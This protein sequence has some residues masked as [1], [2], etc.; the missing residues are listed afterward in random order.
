MQNVASVQGTAH[1]QLLDTSNSEFS[2]VKIWAIAPGANANMIY[3]AKETIKQAIPSLD[4]APVVGHLLEAVDADGNKSF[5]FGSHDYGITDDLELKPLTVPFGVVIANTAK[6][7]NVRENDADV[8]YLTVE[9]YLWTG[10]Y[11]ELLEATAT[12]DVWFNQSAEVTFADTRSW[13]VDAKYMEIMDI[14]FSALCILG[15]AKPDDPDWQLHSTRPCFPS[16]RI[17]PYQAFSAEGNGASLFAQLMDEMQSHLVHLFEDYASKKGGNAMLDCEKIA[18]IFAEKNLQQSDVDFA[19]REDMTEEEL[20]AAIDEFLDRV[21]SAPSVDEQDDGEPA[22][23]PVAESDDDAEDAG[24][25]ADEPDD[26]EAFEAEVDVDAPEVTP[27]A[28]FAMLESAKRD[29]LGEAVHQF[30]GEH[31]YFY[32]MDYDDTYVYVRHETYSDDGYTTEFVRYGYTANDAE[33]TYA[34]ANA[35]ERVF[36]S[37]LTAD[38][39]A[40]VDATRAELEELRAYRANV[41]RQAYEAEVNTVL[42]EFDDISGLEEFAAIK[43]KNLPIEELKLHLFALRGKQVKVAAKKTAE[44]QTV[45]FAL[46]DENVPETASPYGG[47][48]NKYKH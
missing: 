42:S 35:G 43:E 16:A 2:R 47:L 36:Q 33:H 30:S 37:W 18:A 46:N 1:Y 32:M 34:I 7:E 9:A 48:F 45:Q 5:Y 11:P 28:Q 15:R 29:A 12:D 23:E 39:Q 3:I 14:N 25:E 4:Y 13:A 26:A 8:E 6:F 22:A 17:E 41:E 40:A 44:A 19:L 20:R 10:R 21:R 38:E 31:D 27:E 24:A